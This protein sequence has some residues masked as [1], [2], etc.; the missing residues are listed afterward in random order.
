MRR[1]DFIMLVVVCA[2][3]RPLT[4]QAQQALKIARIG[5]LAPNRA[6]ESDPSLRMLNA[7]VAGSQ[8]LGY[9]EGQ[10][11]VFERKFANGDVNRLRPLAK[12]L[13]EQRVDI[14]VAIST[15]AARAAKQ[16]TS[17]IPIV[18]IGMADPVEDELVASLAHPGGN[19]TGTAF[20]GPELV[21]R[22]LQLL[23]ELV[24]RLSRVAVL[25]HPLAYSERTMTSMLKEIEGAA[26]TLGTKLQ[27]VP[28]A[29][30]GDIEPAFAA[31]TKG[32]AEALIIFPSPM[33][34]GQYARIVD[35]AAGSRLPAIYAARE[36]AE[37]GGLAS[38]GVNLADLSRATAVYLEKILKGAKPA[39]LPVQQP[40]KL[41]LVINLKTAKSL[42]LDITR[43]FLQVA[44]EVID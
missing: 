41:E 22:R 16:A 31:M 32:R 12:E 43:A 23:K 14:I 2:A 38:Y 15:T 5:V 35:L 24:P 21:S 42:N 36:G 19:V 27:F 7:F 30:A 10:N 6:G 20:I 8:E 13:V 29:E 28:A 1:R 33:L 18:A 3:I 17:T 11:I 26:N 44:D 37:L 4:V 39:D 9:T 40:T 34:Y 25:W